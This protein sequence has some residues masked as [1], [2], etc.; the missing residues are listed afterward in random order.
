MDSKLI[1][2]VLGAIALLVAVVLATSKPSESAATAAA[3]ARVAPCARRAVLQ[4]HSSQ[5]QASGRGRRAERSRALLEEESLLTFVLRYHSGVLLLRRDK[6]RP[7]PSTVAEV[8]AQGGRKDL[9]QHG[10]VGMQ[11][12]L[13]SA[14]T[15]HV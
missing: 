9:T 13:L 3:S 12:R 10:N 6:A 4:L 11:A 2:V 14:D 15:P 8:P 5:A 1:G 7:Q